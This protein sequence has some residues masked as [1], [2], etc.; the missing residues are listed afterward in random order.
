MTTLVPA[1]DI[2]VLFIVE[3]PPGGALLELAVEPK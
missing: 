3:I 1:G 2:T